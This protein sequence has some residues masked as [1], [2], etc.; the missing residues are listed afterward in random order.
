M[1]CPRPLA[2]LVQASRQALRRL[3]ALLLWAG[4]L[5]AAGPA[6]ATIVYLG[7][8]VGRNESLPT[9]GSPGAVT[10]PKPATAKPGDALIVSVAARPQSMTATAPAGWI[11]LTFTDEADG[12]TGTAPGGM[13]LVTYLKIVGVGEPANYTW[14]FANPANAGGM[15]VAGLLHF[16]GIDTSTRNPIDG[17]GTVWSAKINPNGMTHGADSINTVSTN[18]MIVSSITFLSSSNFGSPTGISGLVERIDQAAPV[19]S[20]AVGITMQMSTAPR[21]S[22]GATGLAEATAAV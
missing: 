11:L 19:T 6:Q 18:T 3:L 7:N 1:A 15:A 20:G 5:A 14:T 10:V 9:D 17:N 8:T 12:G 22:A 2:W 13:S 16:S 4:L 21:A